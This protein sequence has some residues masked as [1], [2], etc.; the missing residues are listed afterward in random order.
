MILK[1]W[2]RATAVAGGLFL[3]V[4]TAEAGDVVKVANG[5]ELAAAILQANTDKSVETIRCITVGGCDVTGPLPTY[6][7]SHRLII[8][9]KFSTID[10]SGIIDQDVFAAVGG[11]ILKLMRLTI[12]G[13]MTG[14][15]VEVPAN[16]SGTQRVE[17]QRVIV[18]NAHLH[19]VHVN[20]GAN[21]DASIRLVV[22]ASRIVENGLG[23][24]GQDGIHVEETGAGQIVARITGS[25]FL[26]NGSDGLSLNETD[27]GDVA[28]TV[29]RTHFLLNGPNPANPADPDDGLDIDEF[30]SGD[31]WLVMSESRMN[32]NFDDGID[33]DERDEGSLLSN[34]EEV[35]ANRN[36]DQGITYDERLGGDIFATINDSRVTNNDAA[37]QG[38]DIRG[39]QEDDG[40]GTLTVEN[41]NMGATALRGVDLITLP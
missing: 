12:K 25:R 16:K 15:Y 39:I 11:G 33:L 28:V 22:R 37:S 36:R 24:D 26:R 14:V 19:G 40:D 31:V 23:A 7:G 2:L 10:A 9:G 6:S 4:T 8:D 13:G 35:K 29:A 5:A 21:G 1:T 38:I 41:V 20:D 17:L 32:K 34:L 27:A 18:R 30:G 3:T